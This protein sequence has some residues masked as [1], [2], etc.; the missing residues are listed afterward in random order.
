V[1][2]VYLPAVRPGQRYG[3]RVHGPWEPTQGHRF[4]PAKLL[5]DPYAKAIDGT[6]RWDDTL[7][8]YTVGHADADVVRDERD[9]AG[10][11][12][13]SVDNELSWY[14]WAQVDEALLAFTRSVIA[15]RKAHAVF[16]RRR[17][18]QGRPI[19]GTGVSDIA[20]FTPD[21]TPMAEEHWGEAFAKSLAV[22][23]N[24]RAITDPDKDG[25]RVRD[26]TFYVLFNAHHEPLAFTV[27]G[28]PWGRRWVT[29]LDTRAPRLEEGDHAHEA[30]QTLTVE[31][32]S[33]VVLRR[34]R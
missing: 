12:P 1:W 9:S 18:F 30:G 28:P 31:A 6:I 3:Y 4:N 11:I 24:G 32:R 15:F 8:G 2:H 34:M 23:L 17:F 16:R 27:P 10:A 21:G 20:W 14:N 13:K 22:C 25:R 19:H 33:L 29:A 26:D 5:L 7:F